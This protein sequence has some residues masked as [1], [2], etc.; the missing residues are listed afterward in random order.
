[1][2]LGFLSREADPNPDTL[3]H[4]HRNS[5]NGQKGSSYHVSENTLH[6]L[7][8]LILAQPREVHV[9]SPMSPVRHP[10]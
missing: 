8:T 3:L 9:L 10:V 7:L 6:T 4:H 5:R 1:M 2:P